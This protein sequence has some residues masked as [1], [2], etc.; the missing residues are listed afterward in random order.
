[1]PDSVS[2]RGR[3][4][5]TRP[6]LPAP[7]TARDDPANED[8]TTE[9]S[10]GRTVRIWIGVLISAGLIVYAFRGQNPSEIWGALRG[11][12]G[13]WLAPAL[14]LYGIGV[15]IRAVR[16][17][18]LLRPLTPVSAR[19][20]L[21]IVLAG[22][23]ANNVLPLRTGEL[24]RAYLIRQRFGVRKTAA[25]ATIA[26]ERLFDGLTM[27]GFIVAAMTAISLTAELR[28]VTLI[29]SV[30]FA[31]ILAGL[32]VLTLG[33]TTRD[34]L[35][36]LALGPL[37]P[38][39]AHR[40][41][42]MVGSFLGGLGVLRRKGDL[43]LVAVSSIAAWGFEA[44][45]YWALAQGFGG[46]IATA[47]SVPAA[48]LTTGVANL[49]TLVPAAPGYVGTFEAGVTLVATGALGVSRGLSLSYAILVH[50]V[51]WFPITLVGALVW[52]RLQHSA[53]SVQPDAR[54]TER[55]VRTRPG[56]G[57][58]EV[59]PGEASRR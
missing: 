20:V 39:L 2:S 32:V 22:Y 30:V 8:P 51:L 50:A 25:L 11:F 46:T 4:I 15:W 6:R 55:A 35:L 21:P 47:F 36:Q 5:P 24:V 37:P 53:A 34:R 26:V 57:G 49:A 7:D 59:F 12:D 43:T 27:L 41:E 33:G 19:Q 44:A 29:A 58:V 28:Q 31:V 14:A 17:S 16:W 18:I 13:R 56:A 52:W 3:T 38:S 9:R 40:V 1:M 23:T 42:R 54:D 10:I 45:M 48:L